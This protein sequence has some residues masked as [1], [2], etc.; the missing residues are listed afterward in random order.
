[1]LLSFHF[2]TMCGNLSWV[3][4]V[5]NKLHILVKLISIT[6]HSKLIIFLKR[7]IL[8]GAVIKYFGNILV[9]ICYLFKI[10]SNI[11]FIF[12]SLQILLILP[13]F[14]PPKFMFIFSLHKTQTNKKTRNTHKNILPLI[15]INI[16]KNIS[17]IS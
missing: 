17:K 10:F 1:M 16:L 7:Q 2:N 13:I 3:V 15:K 4:L 6:L 9:H 5:V 14:F 11:L 8:K 12:S